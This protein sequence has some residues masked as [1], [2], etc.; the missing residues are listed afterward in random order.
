MFS[1]ILIP[2]DLH[3]SDPVTK[4]LDVAADLAS[5]YDAQVTLV[6]VAGPQHT[7]APHHRQDVNE[8]LASLA[9]DM[10][11]KTGSVV[12]THSVFTSDVP[13]EVDGIL[14]SAVNELDA[15]LV[16]VGS[17]VPHLMDYVFSSHAGKLANHAKCS[18]FVVR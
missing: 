15:D 12:K 2:V 11:K 10:Q 16:V 14:M 8:A 6:S 9:E 3:L 7:D 5:T 18:V 1:R 13:A 17:H 4:S